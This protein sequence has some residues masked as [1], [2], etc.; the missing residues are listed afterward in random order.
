MS[1]Q[2][3]L[4]FDA[5]VKNITQVCLRLG[6][7][8]QRKGSE[9]TWD[10]AKK[11]LSSFYQKLR[12]SPIF[13]YNLSTIISV[14]TK[15]VAKTTYKFKN[16]NVLNNVCL[17]SEADIRSTFRLALNLLCLF[18]RILISTSKVWQMIKGCKIIIH[19]IF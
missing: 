15:F 14:G 17:R 9:I 16:T 1:G 11:V 8:G 10:K 18:N 4:K 12:A 2:Y 13:R 19:Q 3:L 6:L 7:E 5:F